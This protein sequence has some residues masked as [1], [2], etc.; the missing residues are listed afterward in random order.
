MAP[1]SGIGE[2]DMI[3]L[4]DKKRS[5]HAVVDTPCLMKDL[6]AV[7]RKAVE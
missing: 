5:Q 3:E 7:V 4:H 6:E 1:S 2:W